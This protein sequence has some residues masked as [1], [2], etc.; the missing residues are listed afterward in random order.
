MATPLTTKDQMERYLSLCGIIMFSDHERTG[1]E[2]DAVIDDCIRRASGELIG[3]IYPT[4][5]VENIA[6]SETVGEWATAISCFYLCKRRGNT[7]PESLYEDYDRI[8][9]KPDG[10][11]WDLRRGRFILPEIPKQDY[12][13]PTFSNLTVDRRFRREKVRVTTAN[14]SKVPTEIEQDKAPEVRRLK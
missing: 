7:P 2:I 5:S 4:Y 10:L 6:L 1:V 11:V 3:Y 12:G 14:S 9:G 13:T 8:M